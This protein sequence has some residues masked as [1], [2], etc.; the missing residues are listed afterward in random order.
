MSIPRHLNGDEQDA[1]R[2]GAG[3]EFGSSL[4][5]QH[6][7]GASCLSGA[8][9]TTGHMVCRPCVDP[10]CGRAV[11]DSSLDPSKEPTL[12]ANSCDQRK[13]WVL[14]ESESL[15]GPARIAAPTS[16]PGTL[17]CSA[18]LRCQFSQ[19]PIRMTSW[20]GHSLSQFWRLKPQGTGRAVLPLEAL[21]EDPSCLFLLLGAPGIPWLWKLWSSFLSSCSFS[22]LLSLIKTSVI[23]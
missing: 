19:L 8:P 16:Q 22:P 7:W 5:G 14:R 17:P 10:A 6:L 18:E 23:T 12:V 1:L 21:G 20:E 2:G 4:H 9:K 11:I 3:V 13:L 15:E